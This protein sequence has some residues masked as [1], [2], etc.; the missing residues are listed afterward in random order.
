MFMRMNAWSF[1]GLSKE[2]E[3]ENR[4]EM[5]SA[6]RRLWLLAWSYGSALFSTSCA[7]NV[8]KAPFR[9]SL[10]ARARQR[11]QQLSHLGV[12]WRT[13]VQALALRGHLVEGVE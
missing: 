6:V 10:Q 5:C 7:G 4:E 13:V 1:H 2:S 11:P 3:A 12:S 9:P 8:S